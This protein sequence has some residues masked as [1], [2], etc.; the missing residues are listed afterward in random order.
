LRTP[1]RMSRGLEAAERLIVG[2]IKAAGLGAK[3]LERLPGSDPG[4]LAPGKLVRK[5]TVTSCGWLAARLENAE[6]RQR[7][8][9]VEKNGME[10]PDEEAA[11]NAR[12]IYR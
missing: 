5:R 2:R 7:E 8:L 12:R 9:D 6:R 3:D 4:K 10:E 11:D 1:Q